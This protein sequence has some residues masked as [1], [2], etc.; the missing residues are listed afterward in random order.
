MQT[1]LEANDD[2]LNKRKDITYPWTFF[3]ALRVTV[4][5]KSPNF[6]SSSTKRQVTPF[7][8][9]R[10]SFLTL[11]KAGFGMM[12]VANLRNLYLTSNSCPQ[13]KS[14]WANTLIDE[15]MSYRLSKESS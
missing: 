13:K 3:V 12:N 11:P 10:F 2:F 14:K 6:Y 4:G 1:S 8:Y 7:L 9:I 5:L 15:N